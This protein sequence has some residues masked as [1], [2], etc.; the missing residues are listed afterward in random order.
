[1]IEQV[2]KDLKLSE[3]QVAKVRKVAEQI[4][5]KMR[6]QFAAIREIEDREKRRAKMTELADQFDQKARQGLR[7]VLAREQWR[8]L[9]QIR[10]QVRPVVDSLTSK[11]LASRLKLTE[12]QQ[13]K[14]AQIAKDMAAKRSEL[15]ASMRDATQEQRT[16]AIQKYM[17]MRA[18]ADEKALG[19]LTAEQKEAFEKMKGEKIELPTRR[20]RR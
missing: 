1:M 19:L 3:E 14:V 10:L 15:F 18:D 9:L 12:Q 11:R 16:Q 4:G 13:K 17:K 7:E 6:E 8:R 20:G 2:Q 5:A